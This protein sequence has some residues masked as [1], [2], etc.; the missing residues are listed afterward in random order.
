[1]SHIRQAPD[2]A[3]KPETEGRLLATIYLSD[4]YRRS[5]PTCHRASPRTMRRAYDAESYSGYTV[6][7]ALYIDEFL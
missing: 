2:L 6:L 7:F 1:M 3:A 4:D 5:P